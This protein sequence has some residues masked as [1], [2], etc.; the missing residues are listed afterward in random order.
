MNEIA[1]SGTL[2]ERDRHILEELAL[3]AESIYPGEYF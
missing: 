3:Y 2:S 1:Q